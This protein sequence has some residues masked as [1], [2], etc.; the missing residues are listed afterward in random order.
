MPIPAHPDQVTPGWLTARLNHAGLAGTVSEVAWQNIGAGQLGENARFTITGNG[1]LPPTLVGKFPSTNPLS[2]HLAVQ[3]KNYAREVFF[4]T[5]L[6]PTLHIQ[7]PHCFA[8]EFDPDSHDFVLLMEDLAPGVQIDQ[9][10]ECST[11]QAA[12]ALEE[13]AKLHGPRWGDVQ[14]QNL[15]LLAPS[16]LDDGGES[17][18]PLLFAAFMHRYGDRLNPEQVAAVNR[19]AEGY[20]AYGNVEA[21]ETVIHIDYRLDNMMF[22]GPHPLAVFDWQSVNRG[23][24]WVDVSYF[25]GT[26]I[27]PERRARNER[28]LLKHYLDVLGSYGVSLNAHHCWALYRHFAPAGLN[29]AVLVSTLVGETERGNDMFMAMATRSIRMCLDLDAFELLRGA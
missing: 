10:S 8:A 5:E 29:M 1:D 15:P 6:C 18:H 17:A 3:L 24:P 20:A 4:Y 16:R 26:S 14:L 28:R 23:N 12:L 27:S 21:P 9:M 22:G 2:R 25:M 11:D 7:T 19:F 13:L